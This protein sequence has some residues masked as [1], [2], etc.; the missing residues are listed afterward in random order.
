MGCRK[1]QVLKARVQPAQGW[2]TAECNTV[3]VGLRQPALGCSSQETTE[4]ITGQ[5][6]NCWGV[7]EWLSITGQNV[8]SSWG[9][10]LGVVMRGLGDGGA[11]L[12]G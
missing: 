8:P 12:E 5:L 9:R 10:G 2:E 11:S 4:Y 7:G 3:W 6:S 1:S